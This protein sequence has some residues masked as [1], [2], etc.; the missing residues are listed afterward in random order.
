M[1]V[2]FAKPI[3]TPGEREWNDKVDKLLKEA[4][5]ETPDW[6]E[7]AKDDPRSRAKRVFDGCFSG[8]ASGQALL[9]VLS[10]TEVDDGTAAEVGIFHA[11]MHE[12]HSKRGIVGLV[13]D[14]RTDIDSD[15]VQGK[16]LNDLVVG[17]FHKSGGLVHTPEEAI[18]RLKVWKAES[19]SLFWAHPAPQGLFCGTAIYAVR[20]PVCGCSGTGI[21]RP[22]IRRLCPTSADA[23]RSTSHDPGS[24]L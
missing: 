19:E 5:M 7:P 3:F 23:G 2:Y 1:R 8:V 10:G 21:A 24:S 22:R 4:G 20:A 14:W 12:D 17:C 15:H 11:M 16:G 6:P 18:E 13:D 9:A